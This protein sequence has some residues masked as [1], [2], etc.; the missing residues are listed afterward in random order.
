MLLFFGIKDVPT[1][2][3]PFLM[4]IPRNGSSTFLDKNS[5]TAVFILFDHFTYF[6]RC[7]SLSLTGKL[8]GAPVKAST[9]YFPGGYLQFHRW[10]CKCSRHINCMW[11]YLLVCRTFFNIHC[12][13]YVT[14]SATVSQSLYS[15]YHS[16]VVHR[17]PKHQNR[18][19]RYPKMAQ[20]DSRLSQSMISHHHCFHPMQL[21]ESNKI[22]E[23]WIQIKFLFGYVVEIMT[24]LI[25]I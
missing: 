2:S 4:W 7:T 11:V 12:S 21:E 13:R 25:P 8:P 10:I 24:N 15:L 9:L 23:W 5:S 17:T 19:W 16:T 6:C 22:L 14:S 20:K 3:N 18:C 1:Q